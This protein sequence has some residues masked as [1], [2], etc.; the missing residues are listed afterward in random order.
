MMLSTGNVDSLVC[1]TEGSLQRQPIFC[2][3]GADGKITYFRPLVDR[4]GPDQPFYGLQAQGLDGK[5]SPR[6]SIEE[7]A[8]AYIS[9]IETV[10]PEGPYVVSGY[11]AGG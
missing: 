8:E 7:M 9:A 5:R 3:H 4:L 1:M 11:S 2:V 6:D 10:A